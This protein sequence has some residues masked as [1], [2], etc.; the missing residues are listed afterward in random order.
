VTEAKKPGKFLSL[1]ANVGLGEFTPDAPA[2][3]QTAVGHEVP[4]FAPTTQYSPPSSTAADPEVLAKLEAQLQAHCPPPYTT[5]MEQ[6][7]ALREVIA[8]EPTRFRAALKTS[9]TTTEQLVVALS[10]LQGVMDSAKDKFHQSFE[11]NK[12]HRV[13]EVQASIQQT[14]ALIADREKELAALRTK[15]Q[16]DT[17]TITREGQ[18]LEGI[19]AGFE[20]AHAQVVSRLQA[21]QSRVQAMPKV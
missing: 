20:N 2:H 1:L 9:H 21:Q 17:D 8:D 18:R 7:E 6:Y 3:A 5:F 15:R 13:G 4:S 12:A 16:A 11:E 19:R 14:D 10:E